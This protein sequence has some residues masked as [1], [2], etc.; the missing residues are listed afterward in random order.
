MYYFLSRLFNSLLRSTCFL[1]ILNKHSVGLNYSLHDLEICRCRRDLWPSWMWRNSLL[2]AT[3]ALFSVSR[4]SAVSGS[5]LSS[6]ISSLVQSPK[7]EGQLLPT[8]GPVINWAPLCCLWLP[9]GRLSGL[10]FSETT[11]SLQI[12]IRLRPAVWHT[13]TGPLLLIELGRVLEVTEKWTVSP[14]EACD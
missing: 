2:T 10:R 14:N 7:L 6:L 3:P 8:S 5:I 9:S 13:S 1:Y 12:I 4:L 11:A